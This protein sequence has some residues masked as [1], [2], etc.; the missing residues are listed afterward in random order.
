MPTG[1]TLAAQIVDRAEDIA[2][3]VDTKAEA[4]VGRLAV[5]PKIESDQRKAVLMQR[6]EKLAPKERE[7]FGAIC[8]KQQA[9]EIQNAAFQSN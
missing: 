7:M 3:L 6:C 1:I 8:P 4:S 5:T 2:A 9:T